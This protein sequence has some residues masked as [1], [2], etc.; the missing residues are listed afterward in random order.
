MR[1]YGVFALSFFSLQALGSS[2]DYLRTCLN[3]QQIGQGFATEMI[4]GG[5]DVPRPSCSEIKDNEFFFQ[6]LLKDN[7]N[8]YGLAEEY[9]EC[10]FIGSLD[11]AVRILE[12]VAT[13]CADPALRP[14]VP[15]CDL[16]FD[17]LDLCGGEL[18]A[19]DFIK[20]R[21][22]ILNQSASPYFCAQELSRTL[23]NFTAGGRCEN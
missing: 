8:P 21:K 11:G 10:W 13:E 17:D 20:A 14:T 19:R 15:A 12:S 2:R 5:Q 6:G 4:L 1:F 9:S 16:N 3:Y 7:P 18:T 22:A 23:K